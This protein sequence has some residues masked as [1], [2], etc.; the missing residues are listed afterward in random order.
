MFLLSI[1]IQH[2]QYIYNVTFSIYIIDIH[3]ICIILHTHTYIYI[4]TYLYTHI[5]QYVRIKNDALF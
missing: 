4:Y 3:I 2:I 5:I 1:Y